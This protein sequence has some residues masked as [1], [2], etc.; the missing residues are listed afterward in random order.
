MKNIILSIACSLLLGACSTT[1]TI[2][3]NSNM[4]TIKVTCEFSHS[5]DT[6]WKTFFD[7]FDQAYRFNPNWVNSGWI[8]GTTAS[9]VGAERFMQGDEKGKKM[10]Y[11]RITYFNPSEKKLRFEIY[12]AKGVPL[13][14]EAA[15][16]ESNLVSLSDS[17]TQFSIEFNYRTK[18]RF[19]AMFAHK[20]LVKEFNEMTIAMRHY[21]NTGETVTKENFV[22]ISKG[23]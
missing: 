8:N 14:T 7:G 16:G 9:G 21:I 11:E 6:V 1:K 3:N 15:F 13:D 4:R 17:L 23:Y 5:I 2:N 12:K 22:E 20:G 19:L 10:F 18:P